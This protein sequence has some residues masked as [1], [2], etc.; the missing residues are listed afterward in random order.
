MSEYHGTHIS[1]SDL[2][3]SMDEYVSVNIPFSRAICLSVHDWIVVTAI[4]GVTTGITAGLWFARDDLAHKSHY[5]LVGALIA[6]TAPVSIPTIA[7]AA[8]YERYLM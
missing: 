6:I 7:A 8:L 4:A 2:T 1:R 5:P 3:W